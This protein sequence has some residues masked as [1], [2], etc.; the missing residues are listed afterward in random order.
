VLDILWKRSNNP[1]TKWSP[2]LDFDDFI[3][4]LLHWK[5]TTSTSPSGRHLGQY[6]ALVTA[7]CN[8]N[9]EFSRPGDND[10][11]DNPTTQEKAEQT[12]QLIHSVTTTAATRGFYLQRWIEVINVMIYKKPGVIELDKL[13]VIHLFKADFILLVGVYFGRRA[14]HH[15]VNRNLIHPG[16][17]GKPGGECQDVALSKVLPI[18]MAFFTQTPMGQFESD[19]TACFDREV[20]HFVFTCFHSRGAPIWPL[21]MWE[22]VLYHVVHRVKTAHGLSTATY[23]L[24]EE[25]LIHGP[26]QGSRGGLASCSTMTS[27]LIEGMDGLCHELTFSDPSQ[28]H[29]YS[30]T[31]NMF[32]DDGSNCTD[33][34]LDW[35]Y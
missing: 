5:E 32:I 25:S 34:F 24:S 15:Q 7:I 3:S 6:K 11:N 27:L 20:V 1:T 35:L 26:G 31:I 8:S 10:D 14:M 16:Q 19:A 23:E 4:G 21:W 12:L 33:A 22:Q 18:L 29:P 30:T 9:G 2:D 28:A 17:F 13:R